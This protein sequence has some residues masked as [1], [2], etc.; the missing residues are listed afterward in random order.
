MKG[1]L[2]FPLAFLYTITAQAQVSFGIFAGPHESSAIYSVK[3]TKQSTDYKFGF[4]IGAEFKIPFENKL[5]FSPAVSYRELGYKV[6]FNTPSYPP[7]LLAINNNTRFHEMDLDFL[8]QYDFGKKPGKF[9]LKAGPS[10][11]LIVAGQEHFD[12]A[13]GEHVDRPMKFSVL[14]SYGRYGA[15]VVVQLGFETTHGLVIQADFVQDLISMNNEEEGPSIRNRL[16]G[17]TIGKYLK[18]KK[19]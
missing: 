17:I 5:S 15:A 2:I 12:L 8:L 6:V 9:F 19:K 16:L 11:G 13:T 3:N 4:H 14:N 10:L 7:D 18:S 1:I